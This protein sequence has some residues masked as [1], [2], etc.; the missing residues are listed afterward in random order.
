MNSATEG[1]VIPI[2]LIGNEKKISLLFSMINI[3]NELK[4]K[5]SGYTTIGHSISMYLCKKII[6]FHRGKI[7]IL[8]DSRLN[9]VFSLELPK[10]KI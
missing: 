5:N 3:T 8:K 1:D 9:N 10:Y 4:Q 2:S 7:S 6:E